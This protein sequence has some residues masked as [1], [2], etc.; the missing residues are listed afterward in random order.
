MYLRYPI[1]AWSLELP[2]GGGDNLEPIQAA[3]RELVEETG[4][5]ASDYHHIASLHLHGIL[6]EKMHV[7]VMRQLRQ[8][9]EN[10]QL[11]E[12]INAM[13]FQSMESIEQLVIGGQINDS[14]T[15]AALH[16][17]NCWLKQQWDAI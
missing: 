4:I 10:H 17:Y 5:V 3:M 6:S 7:V 16:V 9:G 11:E 13:G 14:H 1:N 15:I 12:G 2:G 8:T